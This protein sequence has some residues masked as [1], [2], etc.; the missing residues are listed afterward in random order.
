MVGACDDRQVAAPGQDQVVDELAYGGC[1]VGQDD[2]GVD[3]LGGPVHQHEVVTS[4][5]GLPEQGGRLDGRDHDKTVH[6]ALEQDPD[7]MVLL[8]RILVRIA[9]D[10]GEARSPRGVH[11]GPGELGEEGVEQ[12]GDHQTNGLR[13]GRAQRAGKGVG[14]EVQLPGHGQH[15]LAH[16]CRR[17]GPAGEDA[18]DRGGRDVRLS[19]HVLDRRH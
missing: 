2:R 10:D 1:A 13:A 12:V 8:D 5:S 3:V 18:R 17:V 7:V 4:V 9:H 11:H 19:C 14:S 16:L 15:A 6:L